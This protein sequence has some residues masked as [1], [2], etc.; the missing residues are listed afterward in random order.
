MKQFQP[1]LQA[2]KERYGDDKQKLNA[3]TMELYQKEKIN[4]LGGCLPMLIQ[5]P[6]FFALLWVLQESVELRQAPFFGWI[7]NLSA[8]DPLFH[9][10]DSEWRRDAGHAMAVARRARHGSDA[11]AHDEDDAADLRG[12]VRLRPGGPGLYWTVNGWLSLLQQWII[13]RRVGRSGESES[14]M[15]GRCARHAWPRRSRQSRPRPAP[16]AS[17]SSACPDRAAPKSPAVLT[18]KKLKPRIFHF[19]TF[20]DEHGAAIDRG[21][22]VYFAAPH[23][24]TGED[25]LELQAHG[26]PVLLAMLL[27]RVLA[28][29]ARA[30]ATG[31]IFRTRVP[32]RQAR[33]GPGRSRRGPDR[34]Q[35]GGRCARCAAQPRRRIFAAVR[36]CIRC[37][38]ARCAPGSKRRSTFPRKKSISSARHNW[39]PTWRRCKRKPRSCSRPR[40]EAWCCATGC[41]SVIVGRPNTGKSSLLNAL[42]HKASVRSSPR[43]AGTHTRCAAGNA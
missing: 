3:A 41:M 1:R 34:Q 27:R 4:P 8:P 42:A 37:A 11:G 18:G 6:I 36:E 26:S 13:T 38:G 35:F 9:P 19:A 25:V 40:A 16:A 23:S 29:G 39:P 30:R 15:I 22:A 32:Q 17:A 24:Y 33:S 21:L 7:Q 43:F 14:L 2:L 12:D 5:M 10:A 20:R 31:R 28:L